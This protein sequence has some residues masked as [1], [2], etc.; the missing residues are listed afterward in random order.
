MKAFEYIH[1]KVQTQHLHIIKIVFS[2]FE[3]FVKYM[4]QQKIGTVQLYFEFVPENCRHYGR[5]HLFPFQRGGEESV[6]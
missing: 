3:N 4:M 5:H 6:E 1:D 2:F